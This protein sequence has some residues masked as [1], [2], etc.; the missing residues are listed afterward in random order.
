MFGYNIPMSDITPVVGYST[1]DFF[2]SNPDYCPKDPKD[3]TKYRQHTSNTD[4]TLK[5]H[6]DND[7]ET[8]Y[9]DKPN[10]PIDS[11]NTCSANQ[12][13]ATQLAQ[14]NNQSQTTSAKYKYSLLMYNRE[15]MRTVNYLA[16]VGLLF[17]YLY[18]NR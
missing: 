4:D 6:T 2:Y 15:L 17:G 16:G 12:Y 10:T 8:E 14:M 9:T 1:N 13:Y 5:S 7:Y 3:Q 11:T 18:M